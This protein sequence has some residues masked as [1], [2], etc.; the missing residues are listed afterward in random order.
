MHENN[1]IE[2][3]CYNQKVWVP[4]DNTITQ[5]GHNRRLIRY[6]DVLLMAAEALNENNKP[7]QALEYLNLVRE[8]ARQGNNS[9]LPDITETGKGC[10]P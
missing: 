1:V 9:I 8:R 5:Y 10:A 3:E 6:A 4:G 7:D 2:V